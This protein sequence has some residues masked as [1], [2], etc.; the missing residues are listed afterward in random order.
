MK[1]V[2][3]WLLWLWLALV[4]VLAYVGAPPMQ[5]FV[6]GGESSRILFFHVPMAW[7]AFVAF[8][9]AG[10][11]SARYLKSRHR[12]HDLAASVAVEIGLVFC[13]LATLSGAIWARVEWGAFWNWDPRQLSITVLLVYYAAYLALRSQVA[14]AEVRGRV[15]GAYAVLGLFVAPFLFFVAPRMVPISLHPQPVINKE[16]VTGQE[17]VGMDPSILLILLAGSLGFTVLFFWLHNLATRLAVLDDR[18]EA[19]YPMG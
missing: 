11:W 13:L 5:G 16:V 17:P 19:G 6:G 15:S 4:V 8:I 18:N 14:D 3:L 1:T 10:V 7:T 9:A 2:L 12:R